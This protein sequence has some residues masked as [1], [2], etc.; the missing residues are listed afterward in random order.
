MA[1]KCQLVNSGGS[2]LN[3]QGGPGCGQCF[4]HGGT[5][6]KKKLQA[7]KKKK[8]MAKAHYEVY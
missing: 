5:E 1:D 4:L 2:R 7:Q 8:N 3:L 6:Q